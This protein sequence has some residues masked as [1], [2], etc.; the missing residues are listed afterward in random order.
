MGNKKRAFTMQEVLIAL[1][2]LGV[3]A[4]LLVLNFNFGKNQESLNSALYDKVYD[5]VYTAAKSSIFVDNK[6]ASMLTSNAENL[7]DSITKNLDV[8]S[9]W[10][11]A[12]ADAWSSCGSGIAGAMNVNCNDMEGATLNNGVKIAL[13]AAGDD[14]GNFKDTLQSV[15]TGL[16]KHTIDIRQDDLVGA[17][18]IDI[19]GNTSPNKTGKDQFVVPV[20]NDGLGSG[21]GTIDGGQGSSSTPSSPITD[22]DVTECEKL[23]TAANHR[24]C[25]IQNVNGTDRCICRCEAHYA[26]NEYDVCIKDCNDSFNNAHLADINTP[27]SNFILDIND[28]RCYKCKN[29]QGNMEHCVAGGKAIWNAVDCK[30][31]ECKGEAI[32]VEGKCQCPENLEQIC[33]NANADTDTANCTCICKDE[34]TY[35]MSGECV[36][37]GEGRKVNADKN[38]CEC[39]VGDKGQCGDRGTYNAGTCKCDCDNGVTSQGMNDKASC[40]CPAGT[41]KE[42]EECIP[43]AIGT[44]RTI[45]DAENEC[46]ACTENTTTEVAGAVS[47]EQCICPDGYYG[48]YVQCSECPAGASVTTSNAPS[49]TDIS[50]CVCKAGYYGSGASKCEP[51]EKA[52]LESNNQ[53]YKNQKTGECSDLII[54]SSP[55][56]HAGK[57]HNTKH[58]W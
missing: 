33:A 23:G 21:V 1:S 35:Y 51:C 40:G 7:R 39:L 25:S 54:I 19:N 16:D 22:I 48:N 8:A 38:G 28:S 55:D 50:S 18:L 12:D 11:G 57:N 53:K 56:S 26:E 58:I 10:N 30:C 45:D 20:Y 9:K 49:N 34:N 14:L 24:V 41:Y 27:G 37:C 52:C 15:G 29:E 42:G 46:I 47:P 32:V 17:M 13:V 44:Y 43:C 2:I 5:D 36:N 4:L 6:T 3:L 31:D